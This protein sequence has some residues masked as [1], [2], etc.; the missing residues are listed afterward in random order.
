MAIK[1]LFLILYGSG[2]GLSTMMHLYIKLLNFM[3]HTN[4]CIIQFSLWLMLWSCDDLKHLI[5]EK[6]FKLGF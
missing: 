3:K 5:S 1:C 2:M 6:V 4:I